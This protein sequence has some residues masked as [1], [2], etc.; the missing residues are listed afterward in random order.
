MSKFE[1]VS[2]TSAPVCRSVQESAPFPLPRN[3]FV[4][5]PWKHGCTFRT[6]VV[7]VVCHK[8][9]QQLVMLA[10]SEN[11]SSA[12]GRWFQTRRPRVVCGIFSWSSN[13]PD[14]WPSF[15]SLHGATWAEVKNGPGKWRDI[16][17]SF[18]WRKE[19]TGWAACSSFSYPLTFFKFLLFI[20]FW[21]NFARNSLL[22][23]V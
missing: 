5:M 14:K 19:A 20:I 13:L 12:A 23:K 15:P 18:A 6:V 11:A 4:H 22:G 9:S 8:V 1:P 10:S 21:L 2:R 16:I 7:A 17:G 3:Y